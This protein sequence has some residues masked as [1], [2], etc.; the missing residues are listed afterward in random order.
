M[1]LNARIVQRPCRDANVGARNSGGYGC[2]LRHRLMSAVPPA[3]RRPPN[4][5]VISLLRNISQD[6][7]DEP[8]IF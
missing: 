5:F 6:L 8:D 3:Q 7:P 4:G 2:R 1:Q